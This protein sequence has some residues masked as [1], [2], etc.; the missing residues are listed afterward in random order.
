MLVAEPAEEKEIESKEE[1]RSEEEA[2]NTNTNDTSKTKARGDI[3]NT[4][5]WKDEG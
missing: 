3:S 2:N 1:E 4:E 5:V